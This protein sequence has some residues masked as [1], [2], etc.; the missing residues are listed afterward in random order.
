[1]NSEWME[2][3]EALMP[4]AMH[5]LRR[6]VEVNSFTANREG[7]RRV[8]DIT[9]EMFEPMDFSA[10]QVDSEHP[11]YGRHLFLS[12]ASGDGANQPPVVLVTHSDTVFPAEEEISNDFRWLESPAEG[13]IYG[14]G[15]VDNKGGTVLIWMM[16]RVLAEKLPDVFEKT[17]WL[18]AANA[19]EEVVASDFAR[20]T[21]ERCPNGAKAV[22][23]FEG[24]PC[25]DG[26]F[27][28]VTARKGRVELE[29]LCEGRAAHAGSNHREGR[30][31]VVAL[32]KVLPQIAALTDGV[33]NL[34]VNVATVQGGTVLNRVPH[35]ARAGLEMRAFEPDVLQKAEREIGR[36]LAESS[37]DGVKMRLQCLGRSVPWPVTSET[38]ALFSVWGRAAQSFGVAAK[39]IHR[40]GLSDANYLT[41][42]GPLL[43]GLGPSGGSAH[44][45][46]MTADRSK[47]AEYVEPASFIIK[48]AI[49]LS[50]LV[51]LIETN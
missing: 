16:L 29:V 21:R 50:A 12:R 44:C 31:A 48:A 23:V 4:E 51:E 45:S 11:G 7:V 13:R 49:N 1:M 36:L 10:E 37:R 42:L 20:L 25:R 8:A 40:G 41:G 18:L 47:T 43:D 46:E 3:L 34:T 27:D 32:A 38:E 5:W 30:N 15:V 14:P 26:L 9:A 17:T 19:S 33:K 6:L 28:L 39:A 22:L 35:E 2:S 24:G